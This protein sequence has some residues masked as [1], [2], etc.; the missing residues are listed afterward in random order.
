MF[1]ERQDSV[2]R[3][4]PRSNRFH[5]NENV[6]SVMVCLVAIIIRRNL[7]VTVF[8]AVGYDIF[9]RVRIAAPRISDRTFATIPLLSKSWLFGTVTRLVLLRRISFRGR[10]N[11]SIV[12]L[13]LYLFHLPTLLLQQQ[14]ETLY[15]DDRNRTR[16][17]LYYARSRSSHLIQHRQLLLKHLLFFT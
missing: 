17:I 14:R 10:S 13:F 4:L 8:T 15:E 7:D 5:R 16:S 6:D 2:L 1:I 3:F 11:A 12:C 9:G